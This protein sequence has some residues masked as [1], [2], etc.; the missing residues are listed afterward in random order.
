MSCSPSRVGLW[1]LKCDVFPVLLLYL[2]EYSFHFC[3]KPGKAAEHLSSV[4]ARNGDA[5]QQPAGLQSKSVKFLATLMSLD[6][7]FQKHG[8]P[9]QVLHRPLC[10]PHLWWWKL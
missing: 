6:C 2:R 1:P 3:S 9:L 4:A 10:F 7:P 5:H 8:W